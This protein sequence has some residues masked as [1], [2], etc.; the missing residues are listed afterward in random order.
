MPDLPT[1]TGTLR[2]TQ[3]DRIEK[4]LRKLG[5][6]ARVQGRAYDPLN[7]EETVDALEARAMGR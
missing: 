6:E 7:I 4:A 3:A 2:P 5:F 1:Y